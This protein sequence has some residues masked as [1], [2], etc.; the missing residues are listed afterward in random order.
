MLEYNYSKVLYLMILRTNLCS[1]TKFHQEQRQI[2]WLMQS[3]LN[4]QEE[5]LAGELCRTNHR[6]GGLTSCF[7]LELRASSSGPWG[8]VGDHCV[9]V[10]ISA[11]HWQGAGAITTVSGSVLYTERWEGVRKETCGRFKWLYNLSQTLSL[12]T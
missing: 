3:L 7:L 10:L 12:Q 4:S 8:A 5:S 2:A 11:L 9:R 6:G 1:K